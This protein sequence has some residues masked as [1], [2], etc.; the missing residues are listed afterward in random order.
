M[1]QGPLTSKGRPRDAYYYNVECP[2]HGK[3]NGICIGKNLACIKCGEKYGRDKH[4]IK[5]QD[6]K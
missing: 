1:E 4:K 6:E 2:E 5:L 3:T